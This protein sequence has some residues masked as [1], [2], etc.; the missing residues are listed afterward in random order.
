MNPFNFLRRLNAI[1]FPA[2]EG[3][4]VERP[5]NILADIRTIVGLVLTGATSPPLAAIE[6]N[7]LAIV[8]AANQTA[9]GTFTFVVPGDYDSVADILT[10]PILVNS[11]GATN[12]PTLDGTVYRKRAGA[13]LSADLDPLVS[14]AI[15]A[16]IAPTTSQAIRV[17][18]MSGKACRAGDVLTVNIFTAAHTTDAVNIF[19]ISVVYRSSIVFA[20]EASR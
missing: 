11:S 1:P 10:F 16:T 5:L 8:V 18:S 19:S 12:N 9:A 13:A 20:A 14:A 2:G 15:P 4:L 17:V 3:V 7:G 6:T